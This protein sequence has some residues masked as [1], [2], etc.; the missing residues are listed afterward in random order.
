[1]LTAYFYQ[2]DERAQIRNFRTLLPPTIKDVLIPTLYFLF[3]FS[4]WSV[5]NLNCQEKRA[6]WKQLEVGCIPSTS[7]ETS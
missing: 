1:L 7:K 3:F 6:G 5:R 2:K 4:L